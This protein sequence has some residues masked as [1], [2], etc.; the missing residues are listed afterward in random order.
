MLDGRH[1]GRIRK[2]AFPDCKARF[3]RSDKI[4]IGIIDSKNKERYVQDDA[5]L[6]HGFKIKKDGNYRI[7]VENYGTKQIDVGGY[8]AINPYITK[9]EDKKFEESN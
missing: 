6:W 1:C 4:A 3:Q 7:F 5:N 9:E 2:T 8:C